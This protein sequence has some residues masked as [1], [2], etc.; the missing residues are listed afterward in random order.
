[1]GEF[2]GA[3]NTDTNSPTPYTRQNKYYFFHN[4]Y[5]QFFMDGV[6]QYGDKYFQPVHIPSDKPKHVI[7]RNNVLNDTGEI[8]SGIES[9]LTQILKRR[10]GK[11]DVVNFNDSISKDEFR[12]FNIGKRALEALKVDLTEANL[13]AVAAKAHEI[14]T[15][16]AFKALD[17][18]MPLELTFDI[19]RNN[20]IL[21]KLANKVNPK[22]K[23]NI[24]DREYYST[25][26]SDGKKTY[27]L[28]KEDL[29]PSF[30]LFYKNH[31]INSFFLNQLIA[32]D[33]AFYKSSAD[34]IKRYAGVFAPGTKGVVDKVIG[35]REKF[36]V[37]SLSD[38]VVSK[39]DT[40]SRLRELIFSGKTPST[41]Q[42]EEFNRLV[43]FF[44][45]K[46]YEVTDAQGFM[47][48]NRMYD[49]EKGFGRS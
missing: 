14:L 6:R 30:D 35:M 31:Y 13:K 22:Y 23:I 39:E 26:R 19:K 41:V 17:E 20:A 3:L 38:T 49:I 47:T 16:D 28:S 18:V 40:V 1:M 12:N 48:P 5:L 7:V 37:L 44:G 42:E 46:G 36:R 24:S 8:L 11:F 2:E 10:V 21:A 4:Y 29:A 15:E 43:S 27:L 34:I 32:G 9:A 45:K 33:P 25:K